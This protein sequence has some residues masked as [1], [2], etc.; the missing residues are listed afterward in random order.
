MKTGYPDQ[1]NPVLFFTILAIIAIIMFVTAAYAGCYMRQLNQ[2]YD[3][4]AAVAVGEK[5]SYTRLSCYLAVNAGSHI[6]C[7]KRIE[8]ALNSGKA[9]TARY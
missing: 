7:V 1:D 8:I 6:S 4:G 5:P 2:E 9:I 3:E